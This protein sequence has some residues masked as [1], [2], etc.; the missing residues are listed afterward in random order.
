MARRPV[1]GLD[2]GTSGVRAAE[3]TLGKG[4]ITLERFGQVALPPGAVRNG[5][6]ADPEAVASAIK[7]LWAQAKFG[8][9]K[10]VVGVANQKVIVRQVDLPWLPMAE[11]RKS[12]A[13]QVQDYIPMPVEEAI[14]DFHP[15]EEFT[16]DGGARMVR[17]LLVAAARD[18]VN[19]ALVA[20]NK[21]GLTPTMVDLTSFAVL[22]SLAHADSGL[23]ETRSEAVIDIGASV[24]NIVVHQGGVP[25]FVRILLMGGDDITEALAERLGVPPAQAE[26]VKQTTGMSANDAPAESLPAGRAIDTA[27]AAFVEEVRGSLDY[28]MS[29]AGSVRIS[30]VVLS[31]GGS[32]LGGLVERL[33]A[34][35]R[36][37]VER[38]RPLSLVSLGKTGL[39]DE[40]LAYVEPMVSVPVG[41]ALGVAS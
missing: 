2:I 5:E 16:N 27:A 23:G 15:I 19:G 22:R 14:L 30:R 1:V 32:R 3:L 8:T 9:K 18:M 6:V 36:L 20:V 31:G 39:T 21:A 10:V 29:Q 25:R 12:L 40:Q 34:A 4:G 24:T 33:T 11:L 26:S 35:T 41:L 38:A 28:F 13:F 37:P 7:Q 17:V